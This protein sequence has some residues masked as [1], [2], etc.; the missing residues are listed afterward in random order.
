[1]GDIIDITRRLQDKEMK[2]RI[3]ELEKT[4]L[5]LM[6][7]RDHTVTMDQMMA[8][9]GL[10]EKGLLDLIDSLSSKELV[11]RYANGVF[12]LAAEHENVGFVPNME[13]RRR[14]IRGE[15]LQKY[16]H[17]MHE[18]K[19]RS[20]YGVLSDYCMAYGIK[21]NITEISQISTF[22]K[23]YQIYDFRIGKEEIMILLKGNE[24]HFL[25]SELDNNRHIFTAKPLKSTEPNIGLFYYAPISILGKAFQRLGTDKA[26]RQIYSLRVA[27]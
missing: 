9:T 4:V 17:F 16:I 22:R 12:S 25:A 23:D 3:A 21:R 14:L 15:Q 20:L 11:S 26:V 8:A 18:E 10:G 1:M 27:R 5:G 6:V 19:G 7:S 13:Y 24:V 2:V